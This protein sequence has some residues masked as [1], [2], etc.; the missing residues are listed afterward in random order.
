MSDEFAMVRRGAANREFFGRVTA[1]S[2]ATT[3]DGR[4]S[5]FQCQHRGRRFGDGGRAPALADLR[6]AEAL[7]P[8]IVIGLPDVPIQAR[9]AIGLIEVR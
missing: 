6:V 8:E 2:T 4:D 1:I 3:A 7:N 5:A 9:I